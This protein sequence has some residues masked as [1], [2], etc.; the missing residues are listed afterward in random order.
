MINA[1]KLF[2]IIALFA[3]PYLAQANPEAEALTKRLNS[4]QTMQANFNQTIYDSKSKAIQQSKGNMSFQRPGRFRWQ[5]IRPVP[6]L[7]V[8]ND[9]R[10]WIYDP[11]LEQVTIRSIQTTAGD[12]PALLLSHTVTSLTEHYTVKSIQN[13]SVSS[14]HNLLW[15]ELIPKKSDNFAAIQMGFKQDA[16]NEMQLKDNL[17]HTTRIQFLSAKTNLSLPE[18]L[19]VF[20]PKAG[21]D[22]IDETKKKS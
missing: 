4:T 1:T 5:V 12:A 17:G 8:A 2:C 18:S 14:D 3:F 15:Y 7:I 11:D 10:L 13:P 16:I 19:F 9:K 22:V 6:Q 20:K 21:T